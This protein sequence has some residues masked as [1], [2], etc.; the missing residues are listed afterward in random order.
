MYKP[1][2]SYFDIHKINKKDFKNYDV[3]ETIQIDCDSLNASLKKPCFI[4]AYTFFLDYQGDVLMCP[5]DWGKKQIL[6]NIS[7]STFQEIWFGKNASNLRLKLINADRNFTP[8]NVCDVNGTL[9]GKK[10]SNEWKKKSSK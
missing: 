8:C 6:G 5:H 2:S 3:T 7:V 4:S 10:H 1:D 9:M